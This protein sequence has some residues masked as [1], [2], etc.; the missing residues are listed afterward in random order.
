V[1]TA[2][3]SVYAAPTGTVTG[4]YLGATGSTSVEVLGP[5]ANSGIADSWLVQ[6]FGTPPNPNAAPTAD[7][8]GTGQN[9][10]F[11]Y[12]AGL[13]PTNPASVFTLRIAAVPGQPSQKNLMYQP[14]ASGRTY[15]MQSVT[16]LVAG[17]WSVQATSAPLTNGTQV[18]VSD[19]Y[20]NTPSKFYRVDIYNILTN[21]NII[22]EDSVGDGILD[23]WR[24]E[25]FGG[26][27]TTTNSQSCA[28]CDAD[29]TGQDNLFKYAAGLNPTNPA[30]YL[31]VISIAKTNT[32]DINVI[33]LGANGDSTWSPGIASRTNVLEFTTGT[34]NGSYTSTNFTSTGQTNI[35]SGGNGLGV[36]T[37]MVEAGGATNHPSRFYR[38]RVI[39]P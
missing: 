23:S 1:L 27:G 19:P 29:G 16:D 36:V 9:N 4:Y 25:Y 14:I 35:L 21:L 33:Y 11:K 10:L 8:D 12:V 7:A 18:T 38:V 20:A 31:H 6:Y 3:A 34:A 2:V 13:D 17:V 24:A 39:L 37:N 5:Y 15:V 32:T 28:T 30:A 22:I 26:S